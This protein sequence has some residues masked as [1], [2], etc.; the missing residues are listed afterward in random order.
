MLA[1]GRTW[2]AKKEEVCNPNW[3]V[4]DAD[5]HIVGRLA[6]QIAMVLMGKHKPGYTPHVNDGD[7]VIVTNAERIRFTGG[8]RSVRT[9]AHLQRLARCQT[10]VVRKCERFLILY[11]YLYH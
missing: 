10:Q 2:M 8:A 6:T 1:L 9:S 3:F 7:F 11:R 4:V 5:G